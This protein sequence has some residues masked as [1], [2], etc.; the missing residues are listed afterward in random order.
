MLHFLLCKRSWSLY[1]AKSL[2]LFRYQKKIYHYHCIFGSSGLRQGFFRK[3]SGS[4]TVVLLLSSRTLG[5]NNGESPTCLS[6]KCW[7]SASGTVTKGAG[8]GLEPCGFAPAA[9]QFQLS[10]HL[11]LEDDSP[12]VYLGAVFPYSGLLLSCVPC[13]VAS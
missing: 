6:V 10:S 7:L 1:L 11:P 12:N 9:L 13:K 3:L 2:G 8:L 4:W 5:P